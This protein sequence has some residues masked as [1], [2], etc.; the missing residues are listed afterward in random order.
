MGLFILFH[1]KIYSSLDFWYISSRYRT[2]IFCEPKCFYMEISLHLS[3][4]TEVLKIWAAVICTRSFDGT[5]F[6]SNSS[7][8]RKGKCPTAPLFPT[9]LFL[10]HQSLPSNP[11]RE[12]LNSN[13]QMFA[14]HFH[15]REGKHL[16]SLPTNVP[17]KVRELLEKSISIAIIS[18]VSFACVFYKAD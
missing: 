3:E 15:K 16:E 10:H 4:P 12:L 14:L 2:C 11:S 5:G 17:S 8:I 1:R 13:S 7:K 6:A 18:L 9:V